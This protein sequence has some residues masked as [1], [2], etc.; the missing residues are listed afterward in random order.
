MGANSAIEWTDH[1]FN[2]WV[3]CSKVSPACDGCFAEHLDTR[4]HRVTWGQRKTETTE[5][6]VGTRSRTSAGYWK[7]PIKW[8]KDAAG[9]GT[10]PRV[11]PSLCDPFD[12]QVPPDWRADLFELIAATPHLIWLLLT[13]RP[14][15]IVKMVRESGAVAGNGT[16]YLPG[17]VALGTTIEDQTRANINVPALLDA[18]YNCG[19]A[20]VFV[21]C[22][23]LLGPID[24][25]RICLLPQKPGSER[26]GIHIDALAGRYC[27]SGLRYTGPWD[28]RGPA[29]PDDAPAITIDQVIAGGET[30]QGKHKARP[31]HPDCFRSLR[32]QC[33]D[34][35]TAFH[36]KQWGEYLPVGQTLPGFGKVHGATAVK[37]GRMKLHYAGT[38]KQAP[39]YAFAEHGVEFASTTD[40]RLT[41]R[42]SK[43]AAGRLLD[44]VEH[45]GMPVPRA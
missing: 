37:P 5:A 29:P 42:V 9:S 20:F 38:P 44:G 36:F 17:N 39:K 16:L 19:P 2:P 45:N 1:T 28:I 23:P 4:H 24:L 27:E 15:N 22:E 6:S 33:E 10:R 13:K 40:G 21:S 18:K 3:G 7:Q 41:F 8:N 34:T 32:D 30:D 11:F 31:S 35:S 25:R 14:Q 43:K 26:A 12:N